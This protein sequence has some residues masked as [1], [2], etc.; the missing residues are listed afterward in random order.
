VTRQVIGST[1]GVFVD[2]QTIIGAGTLQDPART[3]AS[4]SFAGAQVFGY[5]VTGLEPDLSELVVPLPAVRAN[6]TYRVFPSQ[7]Q[8]TNLLGMAAAGKTV[9]QFVLSLSAPST[10]G[11]VFNFLVVDNT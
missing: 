8:C 6:A 10:A 7:G 2:G 4:S 1:A 5:V 3:A 11:D 9:A